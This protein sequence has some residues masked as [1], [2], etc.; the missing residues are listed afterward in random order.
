MR[1]GDRSARNAQRWVGK[2]VAVDDQVDR[3]GALPFGQPAEHEV[4]EPHA[5]VEH[6]RLVPGEKDRLPRIGRR[7]GDVAIRGRPPPGG[8]A[9]LRPRQKRYIRKRSPLQIVMPPVPK[10][11]ILGDQVGHSIQRRLDQSRAVLPRRLQASEIGPLLRS[12]YSIQ[13]LP[14]HGQPRLGIVQRPAERPL[15]VEIDQRHR[16][17]DDPQPQPRGPHP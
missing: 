4:L 2:R 14:I 15:L 17:F 10:A 5:G 3:R 16:Q 12:C 9:Q 11:E 8:V 6:L 1:V 13:H 7:S